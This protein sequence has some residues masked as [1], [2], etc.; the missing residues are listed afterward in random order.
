M[1]KMFAFD[2][3][4]HVEIWDLLDSLFTPIEQ[5]M[6]NNKSTGVWKIHSRSTVKIPHKP[7]VI[8]VSYCLHDFLI[9][10]H[11]LRL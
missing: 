4:C 9:L 8:L 3:S 1:F 10:F 7:I 2:M 5:D 11:C 6:F